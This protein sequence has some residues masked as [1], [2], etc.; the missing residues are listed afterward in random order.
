MPVEQDTS[1]AAVG[2]IVRVNGPVVEA[3]GLTDAGMLE[4]VEV[5]DLRLIGEIIRIEGEVATIQV[6]EDTSGLMPGRQVRA[7]GSPLC[8]H[9]GPGLVGNIYDGVQRPLR[10]I[11]AHSGVYI[12]RGEKVPP[13]DPEKTW[14]FEPTVKVG[15]EVA[16]GTVFGTVRETPAIEHHLM[17]ASGVEGIVAEIA[18]PGDYPIS[19]PMLAVKT[20]DGRHEQTMVVR[21][22]IDS[23]RH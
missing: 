13:L 23:S 9:L 5:G 12:Q 8:V 22:P 20:D 7:T 21:W 6:Y 2:S 3:K 4:V 15:D 16:A 17:V 14:G 19:H 18:E 10:E 11:R 1:T